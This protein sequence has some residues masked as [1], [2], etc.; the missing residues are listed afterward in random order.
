MPNITKKI[1][2]VTED[3][4]EVVEDVLEETAEKIEDATEFLMRPE[5]LACIFILLIVICIIMYLMKRNDEVE[6][7]KR[8]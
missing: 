3:V 4:G 5:V 7:Y 2:D 8:R 6:G 1:V